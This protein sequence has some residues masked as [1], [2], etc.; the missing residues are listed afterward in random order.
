MTQQRRMRAGAIRGV[1]SVALWGATLGSAE[2]GAR[3]FAYNYEA[4]T[5]PAG[6]REYETWVTWKT[7]KA[8][9]PDFDRFDIRHE[10]EFGITDRFQLAFYLADW[11]YEESSSESGKAEFRNVAVEAIYGFSDPTTDLIGSAVYGEVKLGDDFVELESKLLLQKNFGPWAWVYNIGAEVEWEDSYHEDEA[12]V[13]QSMGLSY[14]IN[15]NWS[16]GVEA[17]HECGVDDVEDFGDNVVYLG[18]S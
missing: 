17:L 5:M 16:T 8:S 13:M 10:F 11:R 15:P 1:A 7:D 6:A 2:A 3:R 9:D 12:E 4:T 14:L 18:R